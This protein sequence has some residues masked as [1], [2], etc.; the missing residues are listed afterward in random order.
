[1]PY[2]H[3]N[4]LSA[5]DNTQNS[6][7]IWFRISISQS[8]SGIRCT[9]SLSKTEVWCIFKYFHRSPHNFEFMALQI[10][11][12]LFSTLYAP[13]H[14]FQGCNPCT[15]QSKSKLVATVAVTQNKKTGI[16]FSLHLE[17]PQ[18]LLYAMK[19]NGHTHRLPLSAAIEFHGI[20]FIHRIAIARSRE[21]RKRKFRLVTALQRA[22]LR[23]SC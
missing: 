2:V 10:P 22:L 9:T 6:D 14:N 17:N 12:F 13:A 21:G 15:T 23:G 19:L 3:Y 1:M 16:F 11:F 5:H 18:E 4:K 7:H 8:G 20:F